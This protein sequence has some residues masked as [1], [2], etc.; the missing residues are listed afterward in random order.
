M[1]SSKQRGIGRVLRCDPFEVFTSM[2]LVGVAEQLPLKGLY[3]FFSNMAFCFLRPDHFLSTG[4]SQVQLRVHFQDVLRSCA[5]VSEELI[6]P[7]VYI[8]L[9][10]VLFSP[11]YSTNSS[12]PP[13]TSLPQLSQAPPSTGIL[14]DTEADPVQSDSVHLAPRSPIII[15]HSS[16]NIFAHPFTP[17][18]RS[19]VV[20]KIEDFTDKLRLSEG[21]LSF[22]SLSEMLSS[23]GSA[24]A[25][26]VS[27][28]SFSSP[29]DFLLEGKKL[30]ICEKR[31]QLA[32]E[33]VDAALKSRTLKLKDGLHIVQEFYQ[34][35]SAISSLQLSENNETPRMNRTVLMAGRFLK[36]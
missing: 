31:L 22:Q 5:D 30:D 19:A 6:V 33:L 12:P 1:I 11:T 28:L 26:C 34:V 9:T 13:S 25:N 10:T 24:D 2:E 14:N 3:R 20:Q 7:F 35:N 4:K 36:V 27:N 32:E 8:M 21:D 18:Y 23:L 15:R 17:D 29:V 16:G